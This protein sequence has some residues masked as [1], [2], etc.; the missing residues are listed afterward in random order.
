MKQPILSSLMIEFIKTFPVVQAQ[1]KYECE[2]SI[3]PAYCDIEHCEPLCIHENRIWV[4]RRDLTLAVGIKNAYT[5][6]GGTSLKDKIDASMHQYVCADDRYGH[7]SLTLPEGN[8]DGT[9]YY[10]GWIHQHPNRLEV[11]IYSG[12]YHNRKLLESQKLFLESYLF[13]KFS[14]ALGQQQITF[15]DWGYHEDEL[16][17][18]LKGI[19]Y[20]NKQPKRVYPSQLTANIQ[21]SL[22]LLLFV[23]QNEPQ[24]KEAYKSTKK[25]II[26]MFKAELENAYRIVFLGI[27]RFF[28]LLFLNK[29][30]KPMFISMD[31]PLSQNE[32]TP[33]K[34]VCCAPLERH[35]IK[36]S[37][38]KPK[39]EFANDKEESMPALERD[40]CVLN[41]AV[42]AHSR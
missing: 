7:P 42:D 2:K 15:I 41:N 38:F 32:S 35:L 37:L 40:R 31:D 29:N 39:I 12:R 6:E 28:V 36:L 20:P 18:F 24:Y 34:K 33:H 9:A 11:F 16:E 13:F 23:L 26:S 22:I 3:N 19:T 27:L 30:A 17:F 10:A 5:A 1:Y 25:I 8:Y 4:L 14:G 21:S